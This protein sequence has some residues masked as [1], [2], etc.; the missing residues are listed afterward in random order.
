MKKTRSQIRYS[1]NGDDRI[2]EQMTYPYAANTY[3]GWDFNN[4]RAADVDHT[5]NDGYPY[6]REMPVSIEEDTVS[7]SS[8]SLVPTIRNYPN[9]F[10][11]WMAQKPIQY[12]QVPTIRNYP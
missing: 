3:V 11:P 2:T 7:V 4:I 10:N 6:L 9:P 5:I 8:V 1:E 12:D